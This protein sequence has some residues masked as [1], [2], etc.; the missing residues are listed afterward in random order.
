M[1]FVVNLMFVA[2]AGLMV[3]VIAATASLPHGHADQQ[4]SAER[5]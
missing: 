1:F 5:R 4:E 3:L 2:A